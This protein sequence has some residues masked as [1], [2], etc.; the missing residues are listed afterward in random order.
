MAGLLELARAHTPLRDDQID[1]LQRLAASWGLLADLC[2]ADLLLFAPLD[3]KG[4]EG[5]IVLGQVRPA[6]SQTLYR[7]DLIGPMVSAEER[8]VVT[9]AFKRDEMIEGEVTSAAVRELV[10]VECIPVRA[11]GELIA[12]LTRESASSVGRLPGELE[13]TYVTMFN[14][15]ARMIAEGELPVPPGRLRERAG[16]PGRRR[17]GPPRRDAPHRVPLTQ[18]RVGPAPHRRALGGRGAAPGRGRPRR[19]DGPGRLRLRHPG[20]PRGRAALRVSPWSSAASRCSS[21][22]RP[23]APSC[24]S[25][26]SPSCAAGTGCCC[27]RTPPSARSTTG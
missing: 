21:G 3:P 14:R 19:R 16:P 5:F 6:T 7:S 10:R 18:R 26:T 13:R 11:D 1:H 20:H 9:R 8:E 2:F 22:A 27:P 17:R 12:V 15:F 25:A 24:S 4:D 23:P